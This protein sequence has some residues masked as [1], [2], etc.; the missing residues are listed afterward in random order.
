MECAWNSR[1]LNDFYDS[2]KLHIYNDPT[3]NHGDI[4]RFIENGFSNHFGAYK[5]LT[6]SP[7]KLR[8]SITNDEFSMFS[9]V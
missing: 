1:N 3:L 2:A 6:I 4:K 7:K 9:R 5:G 8:K